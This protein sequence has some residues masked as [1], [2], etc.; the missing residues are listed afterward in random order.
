[1]CFPKI[2]LCDSEMDVV[3]IGCNKNII[4]NMLSATL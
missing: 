1:M 4:E 2:K 3:D